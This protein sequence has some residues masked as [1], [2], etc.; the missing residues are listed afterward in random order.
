MRLDRPLFLTLLL[1]I[2]NQGFKLPDCPADVYDRIIALLI[3]KWDKERQIYRESRFSSFMSEKKFR[4]LSNIAFEL[5]FTYSRKRFRSKDLQSVYLILSPRFGLPLNE[6]SEVLEEIESHTG[7]LVGSG[8]DHFEFCHLTVQEFLA[9]KHLVGL[10]QAPDALKLLA[11]SPATVAVAT[12][13]S[14]EPSSYL[15]SVIS[16]FSDDMR[17]RIG[18]KQF[19]EFAL[20]VPYVRRLRLELPELSVSNP[21]AIAILGLWS[22]ASSYREQRGET[23]S[24]EIFEALKMLAEFSII[25]HS[26]VNVFERG[27]V[28]LQKFGVDKVNCKTGGRDYYFDHEFLDHVGFPQITYPPKTGNDD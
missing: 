10:P 11:I 25:R 9:A 13:L 28:I 17:R 5:T 2:F 3:D 21:L 7:I 22:V 8:F 6:F 20:L 18:I 24:L 12:S 1:I 27:G 16:Q 19:D 23:E 4:F 15:A 26:I 14:A